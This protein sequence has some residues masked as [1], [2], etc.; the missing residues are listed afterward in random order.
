MSLP[1]NLTSNEVKNSA[2]TEV[3]FNRYD[4]GQP[5][6][7]VFQKSGELPYLP[8]KL[9]IKHSETGTGSSRRRRSV[10]RV[11]IASVSGVDATTIVNTAAYTVID[12]PVGHFLTTAEIA[13]ALAELGS[14]LHT[15]G[16]STHL[17]D[18]TG[19]GAV[20]LLNGSF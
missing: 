4:S 17:Y 11:D 16:T 12:A 10:V 8:H 13:T 14:F 7:L 2:G 3:E 18:G 19:T 20:T 1:T 15:T 9:S 6:T 5:R